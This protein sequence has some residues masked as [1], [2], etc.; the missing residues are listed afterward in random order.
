MPGQGLARAGQ[1]VAWLQLSVNALAELAADGAIPLATV[2]L[3]ATPVRKENAGR[4]ARGKVRLE[5][6][7]EEEL[8]SLQLDSA[9]QSHIVDV[10]AHYDSATQQL[11]FEWAVALDPEFVVS[12]LHPGSGA[13]LSGTSRGQGRLE[14]LK[15]SID[16]TSATSL[17]GGGWGAF[18]ER[19]AAWD[20]LTLDADV[21]LTGWGERC[22]CPFRSFR[23]PWP[24]NRRTNS[25]CGNWICWH[26]GYGYRG[27]ATFPSPARSR[28]PK[29]L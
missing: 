7:R 9:V 23:S 6:D 3:L 13:E 4:L 10:E 12:F 1:T 16:L 28:S 5:L 27:K 17:R 24:G 26:P 20:E 18:D 2:E 25:T 15:P 14:L 22:H 8:W 11:T 21:D 19:L 29:A